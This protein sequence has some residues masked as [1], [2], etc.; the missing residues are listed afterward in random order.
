MHAILY[1]FVVSP[2]KNL[3]PLVLGS[4]I[5]ARSGLPSTFKLPCRRTTRVDRLRGRIIGRTAGRVAGDLLV[6][7]YVPI[8]GLWKNQPEPCCDWHPACPTCR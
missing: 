8:S 7:C 3:A 5:R 4:G 2:A 1:P 6:I